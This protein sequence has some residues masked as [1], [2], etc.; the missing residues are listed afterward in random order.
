M[1][2]SPR[3]LM[4]HQAAQGQFD[5][6]QIRTRRGRRI[7]DPGDGFYFWKPHQWGR[8]RHNKKLRSFA[9]T[10]DRTYQTHVRALIRLNEALTVRWVASPSW[11]NSPPR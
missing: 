4:D 5:G 6:K 10:E 2:T 7:D 11:V 9:R 8:F 1:P 3:K